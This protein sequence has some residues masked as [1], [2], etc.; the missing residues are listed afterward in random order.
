MTNLTLTPK[1]NTYAWKKAKKK[2]KTKVSKV[3]V[4]PKTVVIVA[5]IVMH[6]HWAMRSTQFEWQTD[7]FI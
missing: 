6:N 5:V 3:R 1:R 2:N 4:Q 7:P